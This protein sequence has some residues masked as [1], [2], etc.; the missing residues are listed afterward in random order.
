MVAAAAWGAALCSARDAVDRVGSAG[1]FLVRADL[2]DALHDLDRV[3][4][5]LQSGEEAADGVLRPA[6]KAT[7]GASGLCGSGPR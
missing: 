6:R 1:A 4:L 3:T 7:I 5:L 2:A